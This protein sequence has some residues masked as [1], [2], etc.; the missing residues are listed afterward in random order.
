MVNKDRNL[1]EAAIIVAVTVSAL[2]ISGTRK[3]NLNILPNIEFSVGL[4]T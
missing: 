1:E 2:A 3:L 4:F